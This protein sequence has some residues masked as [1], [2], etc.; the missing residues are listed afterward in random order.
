MVKAPNS[1]AYAENAHNV[2]HTVGIIFD[3][4]RP[5]AMKLRTGV[6]LRK[7]GAP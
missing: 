1:T 4:A 2:R 7:I 6:S 5:L 3:N